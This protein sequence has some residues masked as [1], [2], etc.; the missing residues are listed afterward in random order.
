MVWIYPSVASKRVGTARSGM[1]H[2]RCN[3]GA[4]HRWAIESGLLVEKRQGY[5]YEHCFSFNWNAMKW[6]HDLMRW[7]LINVLAQYSCALRGLLLRFG[8]RGL[9]DFLRETMA[10][11]WL[12]PQ[13]VRKRLAEP[14]QLRLE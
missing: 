5:H 6:F 14:Y 9:I 10:G 2:E 7:H 3:L 13:W 1:I 11:P 8:A 12:D 4:R